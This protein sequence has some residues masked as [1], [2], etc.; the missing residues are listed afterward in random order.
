MRLFRINPVHI[1][2]HSANKPIYGDLPYTPVAPWVGG[3]ANATN[4][5]E[6]ALPWPCPSSLKSRRIGLPSCRHATRYEHDHKTH[7]L[8]TRVLLRGWR[9]LSLTCISYAVAFLSDGRLSRATPCSFMCSKFKGAEK[10]S[11]RPSSH[12]VCRRSGGL[13]TGN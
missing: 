4:R 10:G 7:R 5:T 11:R 6:I 12:T 1:H 3:V 2:V 13:V 8:T 9:V